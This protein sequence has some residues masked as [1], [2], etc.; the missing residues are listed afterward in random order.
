M[1]N[2]FAKGGKT[3]VKYDYIP[4]K[5]IDELSYTID[6]VTKGI[7]GDKLLSGVY[8]KSDAKSLCIRI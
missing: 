4:Q 8:V 3:K 2:I 7:S 1:E 6:K 5:A